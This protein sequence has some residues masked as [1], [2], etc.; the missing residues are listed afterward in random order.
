[1]GEVLL[2]KKQEELETT[3]RGELLIQSALNQVFA[4]SWTGTPGSSS[5]SSSSSDSSNQQEPTTSSSGGQSS[6]SSSGQAASSSQQQ[7]QQTRTAPDSQEDEGTP[8]TRRPR[9]DSEFVD[10]DF[11]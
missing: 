9:L 8:A 2:L 4:S 6:S 5:S 7:Q 3:L 11:D 1:M 10:L